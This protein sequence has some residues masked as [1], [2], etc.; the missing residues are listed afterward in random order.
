[1]RSLVEIVSAA[2]G[3]VVTTLRLCSVAPAYSM[4]VIAALKKLGRHD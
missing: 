2:K 1:V 4:H 3:M